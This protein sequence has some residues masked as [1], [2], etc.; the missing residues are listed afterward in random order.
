MQSPS[1]VTRPPGLSTIHIFCLS[2]QMPPDVH[3][4]PDIWIFR[5]LAFKHYSHL[6]SL[7]PPAKCRLDLITINPFS[8]HFHNLILLPDFFPS[9]YEL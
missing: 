7:S 2:S 8:G 9:F 4:M 1:I 3:Q 6:L 5:Y